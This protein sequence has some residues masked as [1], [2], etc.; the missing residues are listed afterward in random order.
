[1]DNRKNS[2]ITRLVLAHQAIL[3]HVHTCGP[4][5]LHYHAL[6]LTFPVQRALRQCVCWFIAR[7]PIS[8]LYMYSF[9]S[10]KMTGRYAC[11]CEAVGDFTSVLSY[12]NSLRKCVSKIRH[13]LP[14]KKSRKNINVI[15]KLWC[16]QVRVLFVFRSLGHRTFDM[17]FNVRHLCKNVPIVIS[18]RSLT[19]PFH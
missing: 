19:C 15:N 1:M 11:V 3:S 7:G 18:L 9:W 14:R 16:L 13:F 5:F 12:L 4:A 6:K 17:F 8:T 2:Y 10:M